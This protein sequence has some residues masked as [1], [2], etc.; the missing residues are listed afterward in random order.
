MEVEVGDEGEEYVDAEATDEYMDAEDEEPYRRDIA[1]WVDEVLAATAMSG[2][3]K[4]KHKNTT[5]DR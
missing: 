4:Y 3:C 1:M 2:Q 5:S